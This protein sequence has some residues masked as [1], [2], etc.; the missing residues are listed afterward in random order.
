MRLPDP[1]RTKTIPGC[2]DPPRLRPPSLSRRHRL[3]NDTCALWS[4]PAR[5]HLDRMSSS[6]GGNGWTV[7][8]IRRFGCDQKP[9]ISTFFKRWIGAPNR[10][11]RDGV[12]ARPIMLP[13]LPPGRFERPIAEFSEI[14]HLELRKAANAYIFD[15]SALW[16]EYR[17]VIVRHFA[18]FEIAVYTYRFPRNRPRRMPGNRR[19][20]GRSGRRSAGDA[21]HVPGRRHRNGTS[22]A[23]HTG[24]N[25]K[26]TPRMADNNIVVTSGNSPYEIPAQL[27]IMGP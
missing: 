17:D 15:N 20:A 6:A 3:R 7:A 4:P 16:T 26:G 23:R 11:I 21:R 18:P 25:W 9:T 12:Y 8:I 14:E 5:M 1:I 10:A 13:T 22:R 2:G 27:R 24:D 19:N